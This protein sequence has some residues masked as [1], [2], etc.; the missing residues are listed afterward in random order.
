MTWDKFQS[1]VK[2]LPPQYTRQRYGRVSIT[3][4]VS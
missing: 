4:P 1:R 2:R 3:L